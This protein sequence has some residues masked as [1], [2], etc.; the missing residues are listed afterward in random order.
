[1]VLILQVFLAILMSYTF[2]CSW[3][4]MFTIIRIKV[5]VIKYKNITFLLL[6]CRVGYMQWKEI[7]VSVRERHHHSAFR[8]SEPKKVIAC[9]SSDDGFVIPLYHRAS[10]IKIKLKNIYQIHK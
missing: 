1:M 9:L 2:K 7:L 10:W 8:V 4:L 6:K 3:M 5:Y